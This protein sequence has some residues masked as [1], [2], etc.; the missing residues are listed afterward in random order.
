MAHLLSTSGTESRKGRTTSSYVTI[1]CA[2]LLVGITATRVVEHVRV[3][4][5][6]AQTVVALLRA[7]LGA[8]ADD[9]VP[10]VN[11]GVTLAKLR[12][13]MHDTCNTANLVAKQV[14]VLRDNCGKNLYGAEEWKAMQQDGCTAVAG[15]ISY[16]EN[17]PVTLISTPSIGASLLIRSRN[18]VK[19][20]L[21]VR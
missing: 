14:Q 17:I 12:G 18:W 21:Y 15:K 9:L 8:D 7:E 6:R 10:L 2:G 20:W 5:E 1:E 13:V 3:S 19:A 4:W 11:G 16:A